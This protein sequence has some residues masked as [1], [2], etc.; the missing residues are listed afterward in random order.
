[1]FKLEFPGFSNSLVMNYPVWEQYSGITDFASAVIIYH[2][3]FRKTGQ[4]PTDRDKSITFLDQIRNPNLSG[5]VELFS[6]Q[7]A[8]YTPTGGDAIDSLCTSL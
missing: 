5:V 7:I 6:E 4:V 8:A 3:I 2:R 1:M